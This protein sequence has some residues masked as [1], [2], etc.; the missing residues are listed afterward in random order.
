MLV[1]IRDDLWLRFSGSLYKEF[2]NSIYPLIKEIEFMNEAE[3]SKKF[4]ETIPLPGLV[5][6]IRLIGSTVLIYDCE[7]IR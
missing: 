1:R 5:L 2:R 4:G 7:I 3:F 6:Q